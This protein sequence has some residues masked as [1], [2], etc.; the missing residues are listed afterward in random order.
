MINPL[1][2][3]PAHRVLPLLRAG[4]ISSVELVRAAL[5]WI[6][7]ADPDLGAFLYVAEARAMARAIS[8]DKARHQGE[9][10]G[11]LAGLPV[12]L[13]D[14]MCQRDTPTTCGSRILEGFRSPY[15]A[16][17][18]RKLEEAGAV[19]LGKC[20]MDEFA[21]GSSTENSAF[22]QTRNPW[23]LERV[24]GGSSGGSAAAVTAGEVYLSLGSDTGGSIRQPASFCG[25]PGMKPTYG[26]VSRYGLVAFASSLDQIGAFARN[27]PDLA[28]AMQT[29]SGHDSLD[30]TSLP[31]AVPDYLGALQREPGALRVG[32][33]KD[34]LALEGLSPSVRQIFEEAIAKLAG[35]GFLLEEVTLPHASYGLPTY[36]LIAP[37]E[38]SANLARF[39]GIRYGLREEGRDLFDQYCRT[40]RQGFG[41]EVR[42]RI[43]VGT[44]ALSAGY[45]EAFYLKA[46]KVRTLIRQDFTEAFKRVDL[47]ALPTTPTVAFRFG[48]RTEDPLSMYMADLFTIPISLA[49][50][51]ALSLPIDWIP[52]EEGE[53]PPM[54]VGMQL[55]GPAM[56]E[57]RVLQAAYCYEKSSGLHDLIPSFVNDRKGLR[58]DPQQ[59]SQIWGQI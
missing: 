55:V 38:C 16:T 24:P 22:Q 43:M 54:P 33:A 46:Q 42:R 9:E 23:D 14:N 25:L 35:L 8:I 11:P 10:V 30:S 50:L 45:R 47:I 2:M 32:V 40:R 7:E 20:N 12:A 56:A 52:P 59:C 39:D 5:D 19:I 53:G 27:I 31:E 17:V 26:R 51:P 48:E 18:V 58:F 1:L 3:Q 6:A 49:G 13:K 57:T 34:Q 15:D 28:L 37:A 29:I 4:E 44:Y 41:A 21:M 36:Y